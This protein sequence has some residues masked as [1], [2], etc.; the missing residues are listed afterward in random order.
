MHVEVMVANET[1][2]I[3]KINIEQA[4]EATLTVSERRR[5]RAEGGETRWEG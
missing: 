4:Y 5:V 1:R 3:K 2:Q